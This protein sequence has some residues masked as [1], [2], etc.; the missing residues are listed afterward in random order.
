M[1]KLGVMFRDL[2]VVGLG[3]GAAVQHNLVSLFYPQSIVKYINTSW[4]PPVR[5]IISGFEGVV[6]P[7][8]MLRA[9]TSFTGFILAYPRKTQSSWVVRVLDAVHL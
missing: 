9:Y 6:L 1:R 3:V 5:D 8:E 2:R 4:H 7:G